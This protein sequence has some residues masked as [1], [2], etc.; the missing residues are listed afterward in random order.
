MSP[1]AMAGR[2]QGESEARPSTW[3]LFSIQW[4]TPL[5]LHEMPWDFRQPHIYMIVGIAFYPRFC[6]LSLLVTLPLQASCAI[7]V[8]CPRDGSGLHQAR[9]VM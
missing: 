4:L 6:F 7:A 5:F 2:G 8:P 1:T 3:N 9:V